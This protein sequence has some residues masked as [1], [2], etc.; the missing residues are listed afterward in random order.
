V[1]IFF[2]FWPSKI[3]VGPTGIVSSL[4]PPRCHLSSNRHCHT[5]AP[6]HATF[7]LSQDEFAASASSF[8][9]APSHHLPSQAKTKAFNP[10]HCC[11]PPSSD[12]LTPTLHCYEKVI[13][14]LATLHTTQRLHFASSLAWAPRHQ[15]STCCHCSLWQSSHAHRPSA[16]Q[17]SR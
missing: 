15:C 7:P 6:C 12:R 11:W 1:W 5:A 14:T 16:Q 10:H 8:G 17:H 13:S 2:I 4:S 3:R 9:N